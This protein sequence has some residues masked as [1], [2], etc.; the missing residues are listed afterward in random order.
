MSYPT[1]FTHM[2]NVL[3][4]DQLLIQKLQI[5]IADLN[6]D[7]MLI[8]PCVKILVKDKITLV[9]QA[10]KMLLIL[11]SLFSFPTRVKD[12]HPLQEMLHRLQNLALVK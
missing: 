5:P 10:Y 8:K 6:I 12:T 4:S 9:L 11:Y 3:L 1:T 2:S 7:F